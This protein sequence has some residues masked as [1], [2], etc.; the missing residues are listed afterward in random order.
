[1]TLLA[2]SAPGAAP[3]GLGFTGD[4]IFNRTEPLRVPCVTV[5]VGIAPNNLPLG[6]QVIGA[7]GSD[8]LTLAAAHWLHQ[9]LK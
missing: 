8:A 6:V 3:A 1:M 7:F 5:P 2:P 4:P 9:L